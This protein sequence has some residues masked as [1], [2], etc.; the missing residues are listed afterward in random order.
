MWFIRVATNYLQTTLPALFIIMIL[1][2]T[3]GYLSNEDYNDSFSVTFTFS[4]KSVLTNPS[5][6]PTSVI[7]ECQKLRSELN[8]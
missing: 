4:C 8:K 3:Y 2:A 7:E 6:Y 5:E 1:A